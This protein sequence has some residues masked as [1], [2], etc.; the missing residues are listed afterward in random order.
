MNKELEL[1]VSDH[2]LEK[3]I[4]EE[5]KS[6]RFYDRSGKEITKQEWDINRKNDVRV[7]FTKLNWGGAVSTIFL[8][9]RY[10]Y[11]KDGPPPLYESVILYQEEK[12]APWIPFD[13]VTYCSK[14]EEQAMKLHKELAETFKDK[15]PEED[16]PLAG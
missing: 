14:T 2:D 5:M 15:A 7:G 3:I 4:E 10:W 1:E 12:D 8:G 13:G 9:I 16:D 6:A 11:Q